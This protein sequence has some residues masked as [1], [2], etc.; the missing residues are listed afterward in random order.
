MRKSFLYSLAVLFFMLIGAE[1][2][3]IPAIS[4][5][6]KAKQSDKTIL[7]YYLKGDE[8]V[9]WGKTT[10]GYTLLFAKNGDMV[11]AINDNTGGITASK[12]LAHNESERG[13][14]EQRFIS[15]LSKNLFYSAEQINTLKQYWE[16][17][18][19]DSFKEALKMATKTQS[20]LRILVLLV[21]YPDKPFVNDSA[22]FANLFNQKGYSMEGNE[23]SIN[24]YFNAATAGQINVTAGVYGPFTSSANYGTYGY[25]SA[26]YTGAQTLLREAI[27]LADP[28][29]NYAQYC[30]NGSNTVDCVFMIYAGYSRASGEPNAIWPHRS[31]LYPPV[32]KDGVYIYNYGCASEMNGTS[33]YGS[34]QPTVGTICHEFS[35]VLGLP[36]VYDTDYEQN[37]YA[38][39][40]VTNWD[41]MSQGC[42]N[43]NGKCP[44]LWSAWERSSVNLLTMQ[45][46]TNT[47]AF[48]GNQTLRPFEDTNMAYKLPVDNNEYFVLENRQQ[49]SWDRFLPSHGMIITHIDQTVSGW[50]SNCANCNP[51][52]LGIR[53]I[54][55]GGYSYASAFPGSSNVT[56]FTDATTPNSH[57]NDGVSINKPLTNI[58]EDTRTNNIYFDF[59]SIQTGAPR[60]FTDSINKITADT[61]LVSCSKIE[62]T[63]SVSEKGVLYSLTDMPTFSATKVISSAN[64]NNYT[65]AITALAPLTTYYVRAYVKTVSNAYYYGQVIKV[66]TPCTR[67]NDFPY[68]TSF[69]TD[70]QNDC[71]S[72]QGDNFVTNEWK[73]VSSADSLGISS[74]AQGLSFALLAY[75]YPSNQTRKIVSPQMDFSSLMQPYVKFSYAKKPRGARQDELKL[76]YRNSNAS[77]WQ[78]LKTYTGATNAWTTDSVLLPNPTDDYYIAFEGLIEGGYGVCLDNIIISEANVAAFPNVTTESVTDI[79]DVSVKV[80]GNVESSGHTGLT[81]RGFVWCEPY[82]S[83]QP[84]LENS[85]S[86][87]QDTNAVGLFSLNTLV[88]EPNTQYY[89]RTFA[90]NQS[91]VSYGQAMLIKTKCERISV[92]PHL[93]T[94]SVA[95]TS[96]F[97]NA[98]VWTTVAS[99]GTILPLEGENFYMFKPSQTATAKLQIPIMNLA[100]EDSSSLNFYY[101]K[102]SSQGELKV[103]YRVGIEGAWTLLST[104]LAQ[105]TTW[106]KVSLSLPNVADNYYI[107]FEGNTTA[108]NIICV[109]SIMVYAILQVPIVQTVSVTLQTYNSIK[110]EGNVTNQGLAAVTSR[111]ICYST[112]NTRPTIETDM[113][114]ASGAGIGTFIDSIIS[115]QSHTTYYVRAFATN[116]YGTSYGNTY[117]ITTPYTPIFN[118]TIT[119]SQQLCYN[120]PSAALSGMQLTGGNGS[121]SYLWLQSSDNIVWDS[122][123]DADFR[124]EDT[125]YSYRA[126]TSSYFKRV[127]YSFNVSDTSNTVFVHV[128]PQ[129]VAGN[130]FRVQDSTTIAQGATMD[131]RLYTGNILNWQRKKKGYLWETLPLT[132]DSVMITDFP[133]SEGMYYYRAVVKSGVCPTDTSGQ[134]FTYV[135]QGIGLDKIT[136]SDNKITV[137]PNPTQGQININYSSDKAFVGNLFVYDM[138]G[139]EIKSQQSV[140]ISSG[141]N[142]FDLGFLNSGHYLLVLKNEQMQ[143]QQIITIKK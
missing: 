41:I 9:S 46:L 14:E 98:D 133:T 106:A 105:Q 23:G 97:D 94:T 137:Y 124:I 39:D 16:F 140:V 42:Y 78:L 47:T 82:V 24:D 19:T 59:G 113:V 68:Q 54:Q 110:V 71:W 56:S 55:A 63:D 142:K 132:A 40:A 4:S 36:D 43:N 119:G 34:S 74:A 109:D 53:I 141:N 21:Q 127:V 45:E 115:L 28:E 116:S 65:L 93:F 96:C 126:K 112:T 7:S 10:D 121:Y 49:T 66:I 131:L 101:A 135:K 104:L 76:Y 38:S 70:Q 117:S 129:T 61:I 31:V 20:N 85:N 26:G 51:D 50:N 22:Y 25:D 30:N 80:T 125:Y 107:A 60:T 143:L 123:E 111:G 6:V 62:G 95:D 17:R 33:A 3:A 89:V 79:T 81:Q 44:P 100:N 2:M 11:Y 57:T 27:N 13:A 77:S 5:L 29:V 69:E 99:Q 64:G 18:Q 12:I 48:I 87:Y 136:N 1:A 128:F 83:S 118:N 35:H 86:V 102:P 134:D 67:I 138:N 58:A 108:E 92:F 75:P 88:M 139:K 120:S 103:Y 90:K 84:T 32:Q 72:Q 8:Q 52:R 73:Y 114:K 122:A 15:S 130:V 91:L 37:G